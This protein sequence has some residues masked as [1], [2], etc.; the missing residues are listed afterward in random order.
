MSVVLNALLVLF[1]MLIMYVLNLLTCLQ[2]VV[3][4]Q[5]FF[6]P[7]NNAYHSLTLM[8]SCKLMG[9]FFFSNLWNAFPHTHVNVGL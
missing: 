7:S 2:H 3:S 9:I 5:L 8:E 1:S 6:W 4:L